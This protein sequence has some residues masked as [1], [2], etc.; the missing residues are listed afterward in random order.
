MINK[1]FLK[2]IFTFC[3]FRIF[4]IDPEFSFQCIPSS[5]NGKAEFSAAITPVFSRDG[6]FWQFFISIIDRFQKRV[7][8]GRGVA[9]VEIMKISE[10]HYENEC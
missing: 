4:S 6:H 9:V 1:S 8:I 7:I 5:S 3:A 2:S 10:D